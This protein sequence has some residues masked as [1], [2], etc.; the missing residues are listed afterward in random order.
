MLLVGLCGVGF[1]AGLCCNVLVLL[2]L[3]M[4][5][6]LLVV[7]T[8]WFSGLGAYGLDIV[9]NVIVCQAGYMVGLTSRDPLAGVMARIGTAPSNRA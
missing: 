1:L 5:A 6:V 8:A 9:M 3:S 4:L 2:P 7:A